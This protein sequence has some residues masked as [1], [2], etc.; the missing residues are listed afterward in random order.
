MFCCLGLLNIHPKKAYQKYI[1][2]FRPL[3]M[4]KTIW[5]LSHPIPV[6]IIGLVGTFNTFPVPMYPIFPYCYLFSVPFV[7]IM[8]VN[9]SR[10]QK[11]PFLVQI[12]ALTQNKWFIQFKMIN[13]VLSPNFRKFQCISKFL[14]QFF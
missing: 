7:P 9:L 4:V 14:C 2:Q 1:R 3:L 5:T 11:H 10:T 8:D 6:H 12:M 13:C